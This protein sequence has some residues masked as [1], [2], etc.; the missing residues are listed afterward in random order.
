MRRKRVG[1]DL[2]EPREFAGGKAARFMP[3]QRPEG[4]QTG[5]LRKRG[6]RQDGFF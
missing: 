1:R 4:L 6:K 2:E 5:R 3:D